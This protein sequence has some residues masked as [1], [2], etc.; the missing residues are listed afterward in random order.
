MW[1]REAGQ[2]SEAQLQAATSMETKGLITNVYRKKGSSVEVRAAIKADC[3]AD[4]ENAAKAA[5]LL[6]QVAILRGQSAA[7][8][9]IQTCFSFA[10]LCQPNLQILCLVAIRKWVSVLP[11]F[12]VENHEFHRQETL[13]N[14]HLRRIDPARCH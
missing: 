10:S 2:T 12:A 13:T 4:K 3:I 7:T 14:A 8:L 1:A 5:I 6:E 11:R 9:T